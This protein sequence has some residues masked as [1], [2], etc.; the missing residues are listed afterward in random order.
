M[1]N[2]IKKVNNNKYF[3]IEA[4]LTKVRTQSFPPNKKHEK[5]K[6]EEL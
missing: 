6:S 5:Y 3:D 1:I 2:V 4:V